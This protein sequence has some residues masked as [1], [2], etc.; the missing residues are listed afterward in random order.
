MGNKY[1][2]QALVGRSNGMKVA[3]NSEIRT[4]LNQVAAA[5]AI[6]DEKKFRLHRGFVRETN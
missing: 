4:L 6:K 2:V 1:R 3:T 5:Y